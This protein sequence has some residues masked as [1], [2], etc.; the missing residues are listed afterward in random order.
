M[1]A[2]IENVKKALQGTDTEAIKTATE[3]LQQKFFA[4]SEKIYKQ[5]NPNGAQG[6]DPN[7]AAG[8]A[9]NN[10]QQGGNDYVDADFRDVDDNNNN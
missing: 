4:V 1:E 8:G 3:A 5:A 2:E 9:D 6:F 7:A 10:A